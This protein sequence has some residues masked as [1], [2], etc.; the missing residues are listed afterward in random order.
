MVAAILHQTVQLIPGQYKPC[1]RV[2]RG[3]DS[4]TGQCC[5]NLSHKPGGPHGSSAHHHACCAGLIQAAQG[6]LGGIDVTVRNQ[7]N[8]EDLTDVGDGAPVSSAFETLF[9]GASMKSEQL[10]PCPFQLLAP[11]HG[12]SITSRPSQSGLHCDGQRH[13]IC[14]RFNDPDGQFGITDQTG[15]PPLAG[16]LPDGTSHVDID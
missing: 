10:C 1:C 8:R 7:G 14:H 13:G 9:A 5:I 12:I 4:T 6:I 3:R 15:P 16:D 2:R 11:V